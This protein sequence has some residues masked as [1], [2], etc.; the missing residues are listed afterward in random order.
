MTFIRDPKT[1]KMG[2][3]EGKHDDL[4]IAAA[5]AYFISSQITSVWE[6]VKQEPME[7]FIKKE[8][9]VKPKDEGGILEW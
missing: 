3:D 9:Q 8:L 1:G 6:K 7:D 5:I 2:A 4:I